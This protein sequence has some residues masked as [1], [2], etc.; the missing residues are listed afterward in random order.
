M[1]TEFEQLLSE[2]LG[3]GFEKLTSR[4]VPIRPRYDG[5]PGSHRDT[6]VAPVKMLI[7]SKRAV[8]LAAPLLVGAGT[9]AAAAAS[10]ADP[11]GLMRTVTADVAACKAELAAGADGVGAC[12]STIV[13]PQ[14]LA[15]YHSG[16]RAATPVGVS[17]YVAAAAAPLQLAPPSEVASP[18]PDSERETLPAATPAS[19]PS[20]KATP[21]APAVVR[22]ATADGRNRR[23]SRIPAAPS[24][25]SRPAGAQPSHSPSTKPDSSSSPSQSQAKPPASPA[26]GNG[27]SQARP[28]G[29][30]GNGQPSA[31]EANTANQVPSSGNGQESQAPPNN[32][33]TPGSSPNNSQ[34]PASP[35]FGGQS[36]P[37]QAVNTTVQRAA[38]NTAST[39]Q[40]AASST[41]ST[42]SALPQTS[43]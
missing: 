33:Q 10:G 12:V 38:G 11:A 43:H 8:L 36:S 29:T 14:G 4:P 35:Q 6:T 24:Q 20:A 37:V 13:R 18:T 41:T 28:P 15:Q 2:Q 5:G 30:S 27:R 42:T 3:K 19:Q 40:N 32:S 26:A 16:G 21:A 7:R 25:G 9:T 1:Y 17:D 39:A 34:S 22:P 31:G 23:L